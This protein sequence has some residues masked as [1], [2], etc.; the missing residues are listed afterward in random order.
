SVPPFVFLDP[1]GKLVRLSTAPVSLLVAPAAAAS[2]AAARLFAGAGAAAA[3]LA[4]SAP[5]LRRLGE[6]YQR[7]LSG[8]AS[9]AAARREALAL[10]SGASVRDARY[11]EAA[12]RWDDG[13]RARALALLYGI[14]RRHLGASEAVRAAGACS[15]EL[16]SGPP[17][18]DA[19]PPPAPFELAGLAFLAS[20]LAFAAL[21]A[22]RRVASR[23]AARASGEIG[24][25]PRRQAAGTAAAS[26]EPG[27]SRPRAF[28]AIFLAV[29]AFLCLGAAAFSALERR[30]HYAV[31]WT[32]SL[33]LVPSPL[34]RGKVE[35]IRGSA[36]RVRGGTSDYVGLELAD[37]LS[38]W[39]P[40]KYVYYY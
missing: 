39:A 38:G 33:L 7:S 30:N 16:G 27:P 21:S 3:A 15:G 18:L 25:Q 14:M 36:A 2:P 40:K 17:M 37:G 6:L 10:L 24:A 13:E 8:R 34:A 9:S 19:L 29:L 11:L 23:K 4:A 12:L 32:D 5:G 22:A 26:G 28:F 20:A 31:V 35:V 1:A